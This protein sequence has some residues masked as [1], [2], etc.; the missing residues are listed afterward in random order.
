MKKL[1]GKSLAVS[2]AMKVRAD[3][4]YC[5]MKE[6][7]AAKVPNVDDILKRAV[8]NVGRLR[9]KVLGPVNSP[10]G[11]HDANFTEDSYNIL[12]LKIKRD[13][14]DEIEL[15]FGSCPHIERWK[16][17]NLDRATIKRL[18]DI[19]SQIDY[20]KIESCGL[21]LQMETRLGKGD[22]K[23]VLVISRRGNK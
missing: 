13:A 5:I 6:M 23:C 12:Q 7:D 1:E 22:D 21:K 15:H 3:Y 10:R 19:A 2:N 14:N 11:Y 17:M 20:G 4:L 18:C 16:E 9:S 8:Y